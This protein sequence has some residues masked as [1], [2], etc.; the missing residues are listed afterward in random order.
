M[1]ARRVV[2]FVG[3]LVGLLG[4]FE[5]A[6]FVLQTTQLP[7]T[8]K[9]WVLVLCMM[10]GAIFGF[11]GLEYITIRP[12]YTVETK[13]RETPLPDLVAAIGGLTVGLVLAA[14]AAYFLRDLPFGMN[15]LV[16]AAL[17]LLFGYWG[18]TI[19]LS[20][21]EELWALVRGWPSERGNHTILDTSVVIDGRVADIAHTGFLD[22]TLIAPTSC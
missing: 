8:Q 18:A 21:R 5:Y 22:G 2:R 17:A 7:Q 6:I 3:L 9:A 16:S 13:L 4:G 14:L 10:A 1:T 12:F 20:R 19:G 15:L 11:F